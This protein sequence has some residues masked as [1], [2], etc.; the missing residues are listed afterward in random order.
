MF[1]YTSKVEKAIRENIK[2][3]NMC[4]NPNDRWNRLHTL[5]NVTLSLYEAKAISIDAYQDCLHTLRGMKDTAHD[6]RNNSPMNDDDK[7]CPDFHQ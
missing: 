2:E 6:E 4:P 7:A 3:A 1:C 5:S